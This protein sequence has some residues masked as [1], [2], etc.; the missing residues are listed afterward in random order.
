MH[1]SVKEFFQEVR[2][3]YSGPL[4]RIGLDWPEETHDVMPVS[5]Y[6]AR[7]LAYDVFL[8]VR[9]GTVGTAVKVVT[10]DIYLSIDVEALAL[11]LEIVEKR[12]GFSRSARSLKQLRKSLEGQAA[13]VEMLHPLLRDGEAERVVTQAGA[14]RWR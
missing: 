1:P 4:I 3:A 10:D 7:E 6:R 2:A 13:Y 11:A 8:D 12:G 5:S 9:E 14:R